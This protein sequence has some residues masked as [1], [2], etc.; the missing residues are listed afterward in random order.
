ME[1]PPSGGWKLIHS[2]DAKI[3]KGQT[4]YPEQFAHIR[5]DICVSTVSLVG[6]NRLFHSRSGC[7]GK[8]QNLRCEF[9][10]RVSDLTECDCL[11]MVAL[12]K[13]APGFWGEVASGLDCYLDAEH[14]YQEERARAR[15]DRRKPEFE[16]W[17][18][19]AQRVQICPKKVPA[20]F[21]QLGACGEIRCLVVM[22]ETILNGQPLNV[23]GNWDPCGLCGQAL[24]W[25]E[26]C[27]GVKVQVL[28]LEAYTPSALRQ[29]CV[30]PFNMFRYGDLK[31]RGLLCVC[32]GEST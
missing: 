32:A 17:R 25:V 30:S 18:P 1:A 8:T 12:F 19:G 28:A 15:R 3:R 11:R 26:K 29:G 21:S 4:P 7:V 31:D 24:Q 13:G 14:N 16:K 27:F 5:Q 22:F 6:D 2:C 10:G 20:A 9:E 23:L